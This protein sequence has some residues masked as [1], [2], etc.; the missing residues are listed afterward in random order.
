MDLLTNKQGCHET[1]N[2]HFDVLMDNN[3]LHVHT[4]IYALSY[5]VIHVWLCTGCLV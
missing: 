3:F 2:A 5:H 1:T 4:G